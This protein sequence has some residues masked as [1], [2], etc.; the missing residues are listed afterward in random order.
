MSSIASK[1]AVLIHLNFDQS[2]STV[3]SQSLQVSL[4]PSSSSKEISLQSFKS[5]VGTAAINKEAYAEG[6]SKLGIGSSP[7]SCEHKCYGCIHVKPFKC[8][9]QASAAISVSYTPLKGPEN[10]RWD[11]PLAIEKTKKGQS[12]FTFLLGKMEDLFLQQI[13]IKTAR[14]G[15]VAST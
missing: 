12:S 3:H 5:K 14:V 1:I 15:N 2:Q 8:L 10:L 13:L 4:S 9:L 11:S 7:P 6:E